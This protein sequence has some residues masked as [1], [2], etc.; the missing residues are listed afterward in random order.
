MALIDSTPCSATAK[1]DVALVRISKKDFV[2][3]VSRA[4]TFALDIRSILA[5]PTGLFDHNDS[6]SRS[7]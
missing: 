2:A 6:D 5:P 3:V 4:P 1:T 7:L